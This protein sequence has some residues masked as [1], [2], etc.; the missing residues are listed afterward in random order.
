MGNDCYHED[1]P[2][3]AFYVLADKKHT[4]VKSLVVMPGQRLSLQSHK[5]RDEHWVVVQGIARVTLDDSTTDYSYGDHVFVKR[6]VKHRIACVGDQ[7]VEVIEIQTGEAF[8]EEDIVRFSDDY[9]RV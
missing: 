8:P 4:K 7:P 2:W 3:G 5:F 9:D 6:G 1:R